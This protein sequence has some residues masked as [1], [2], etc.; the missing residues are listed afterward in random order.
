MG[1]VRT[2]LVSTFSDARQSLDEV[3]AQLRGAWDNFLQHM[4]SLPTREEM[5]A[6]ED[7]VRKLEK[8]LETV[9]RQLKFREPKKELDKR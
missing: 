7:R 5:T 9:K 6:L 8:E 2:K 4:P 3:P 1:T